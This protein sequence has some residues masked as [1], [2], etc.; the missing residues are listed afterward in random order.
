ML[1][2][3]SSSAERSNDSVESFLKIQEDEGG[4]LLLLFRTS[5]RG[6]Y[7]MYS[8]SYRYLF[9]PSYLASLEE[10]FVD[11]GLFLSDSSVDGFAHM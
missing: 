5:Q 11:T 10:L 9:A 7:L 1:N 2:A 3:R 6:P 8:K 4:G